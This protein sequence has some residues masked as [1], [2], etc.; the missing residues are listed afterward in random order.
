[1]L[2][3]PPVERMAVRIDVHVGSTGVVSFRVKNLYTGVKFQAVTKTILMM[4]ESNLGP[5]SGLFYRSTYYYF[6]RVDNLL[7]FFNVAQMGVP[8]GEIRGVLLEGRRN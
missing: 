6:T 1:M 7:I 3:K 2:S 4:E 5:F 8:S